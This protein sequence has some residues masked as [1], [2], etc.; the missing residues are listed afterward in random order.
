MDQPWI[1]PLISTVVSAIL[2]P[3]ALSLML[4]GERNRAL[5]KDEKVAEGTLHYQ[6]IQGLQAQVS[7]LL[8]ERGQI[9]AMHAELQEKYI[10]LVDSGQTR[11]KEDLD[12]IEELERQLADV[13]GAMLA[14]K[15]KMATQYRH[16][17]VLYELIERLR[18]DPAILS[19]AEDLEKHLTRVE[20]MSSRFLEEMKHAA[21]AEKE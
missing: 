20:K 8:V 19:S 14:N 1:I 5:K 18:K 16:I 11:R 6:L 10:S 9:A 17:E 2:S 4:R 7:S 13:K 12:Q 15:N 21:A 3:I